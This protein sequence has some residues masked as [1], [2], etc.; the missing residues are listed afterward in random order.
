LRTDIWALG[1]VMYEML[2]GE[3]AF[4]GDSSARVISAILKDRPLPPCTRR[5]ELPS[6]L[7]HV[8]GRCLNKDSDERW[9]SAIDLKDELVWVAS[10]PPASPSRH[11]RR[12]HTAL[13]WVLFALAAMLAIV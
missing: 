2:T 1:A 7:D 9:Q 4:G 12:S 11:L 3:R 8:V 10:L 13:P 5:P 6:V